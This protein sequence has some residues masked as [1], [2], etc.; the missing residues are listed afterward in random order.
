MNETPLSLHTAISVSHL[1]HYYGEGS[2]KK[3]ILFDIAI[4][5]EL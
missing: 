2:L 3:Q 4:R 1:N 5:F